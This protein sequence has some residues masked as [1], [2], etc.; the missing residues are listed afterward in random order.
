VLITKTVNIKWCYKTKK[1]YE[2]QG[3]IFTKWNDEFEVKVEDLICGANAYVNVTCDCE[4]CT[5]PIIK[6]VRWCDYLKCV[7]EDGKYYCRKCAI[8]LFANENARKT[9]LKNGL[10]FYQWCYDNLSKEDA[11]KIL[12]RWDYEKN[13]L[14]PKDV[15]FSSVGENRKGY[16][17]KCLEHQNHESEQRSISSFTSDKNRNLKCSQCY[18]L[19]MTHPELAKYLVNKEDIYKYSFGSNEKIPMK[20]PECGHEKLMKIPR[21]LRQG[22]GC[23]KCGD[24]IS[25]PE[26]FMYN[27]LEQIQEL[28]I[29]E[30]FQTEKTFDWLIYEFKGK[31]RKG[32][33]DFYYKVNGMAYGIETDGGFHTKDNGMSGQT[34]EESKYIDDEKDRLCKEHDIEVIRIDCTESNLEWIKNNVMKSELPKILNFVE[35]NIDWLKCQE[36]ACNSLVKVACNLWNNGIDNTL[37]IANELK[38]GRSTATKYLNKGSLLGWCSYDPKEETEKNHG[39]EKHCKQV[40]CLNTKEIFSSLK[41]ACIKFNIRSSNMTY[42]CSNEYKA[43]TA[44]KDPNTGDDLL[45]MYYDEYIVK[46]KISGWF[47]DYLNNYG[48][49][50]KVVCLT[51]GEIFNSQTEG[52]LKYNLKSGNNIRACC[53]IEGKSA[54]KHPIT[55]EKLMW[56]TY[57]NYNKQNNINVN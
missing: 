48:Y 51:T 54:G 20:C 35:G 25:Y 3:Y 24:G 21:L 6:P 45:W 44:G 23:P 26:K 32:R 50:H 19:A 52:A 49:S 4:S 41:E 15:S 17:F 39:S 57:K 46:N 55:G 37:E 56:V 13:R 9:K 27:I 40:I 18:V 11:D 47:E 5:T 38:V 2:E 1:W 30:N 28:N 43:K 8:G 10:S 33:L 12:A 36:F 16:W 34:K 42:C 31:L 14:S 22:F 29:I 53:N 7:K